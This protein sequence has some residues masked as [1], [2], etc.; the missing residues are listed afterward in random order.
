MIKND[1]NSWPAAP[2]FFQ[3]NSS[4]QNGGLGTASG[5]GTRFLG[6]FGKGWRPLARPVKE[7][8]AALENSITAMIDCMCV[9]FFFSK[10]VK[11]RFYARPVFIKSKCLIQVSGLSRIR[12]IINWNLF[13]SF[14]S[15]RS[16]A[17]WSLLLC[18][19]ECVSIDTSKNTNHIYVSSSNLSPFPFDC[20]AFSAMHALPKGK[21]YLYIILY[22][23]EEVVNWH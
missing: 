13:A 1:C 17:N 23:N 20:L 18:L 10:F 5:S 3:F 14:F 6:P 11:M 8:E 7:L 16:W 19:P 21:A 2:T 15:W 4:A 9:C 22:D 12:S